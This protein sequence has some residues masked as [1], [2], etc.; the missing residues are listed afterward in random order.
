M[1]PEEFVRHY[2]IGALYHFTDTRNLPSIRQHGLL[3]WSQLHERGIVPS[4]PG[5]NQW[6]HDADRRHGL[7]RFVHL[8]LMNEHPME[9]VAKQEERIADSVFLAIS[10]TVLQKPGVLFSPEV[11]NKSGVRLMDLEEA[12]TSLDFEVVYRRTDWKDP[13]IQERRRAARK[14]EVLV[15]DAVAPQ[16]IRGL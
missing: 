8:C 14:I 4:A 9:F 11:A 7:D 13:S 3:S 6:S 1:S 15:P 16:L 12:V 10:P 5:G 2:Q